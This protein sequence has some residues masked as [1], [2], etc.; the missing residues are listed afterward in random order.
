MR[1][2]KIRQVASA[3]N[4]TTVHYVFSLHLKLLTHHSVWNQPDFFCILRKCSIIRMKKAPNG[5]CL[6]VNVIAWVELLYGH[7]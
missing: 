5:S 4:F 7:W 3:L 1:I 2:V 6:A